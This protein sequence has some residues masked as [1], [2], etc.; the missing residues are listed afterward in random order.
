M[1]HKNQDYILISDF[2]LSDLPYGGGAEYNDQVLYDVMLLNSVKVE[3][4]RSKE[5]TLKF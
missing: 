2:L 1:N 4:K 5:V 3:R